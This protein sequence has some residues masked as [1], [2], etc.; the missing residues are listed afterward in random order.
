MRVT[1]ILALVIEVLVLGLGLWG[2]RNGMEDV[3]LVL[4][5]VGPDQLEQARARGTEIAMIPLK[6]A[7]VCAAPA[8]LGGLLGLVFRKRPR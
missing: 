6:F 1:S 5:V 3:A 7:A 8:L 4:T 2:Y